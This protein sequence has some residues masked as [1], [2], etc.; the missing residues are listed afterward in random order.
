MVVFKRSGM[1]S[2]GGKEAQ[3]SFFCEISPLFFLEN[4]EDSGFPFLS[5][6]LNLSSGTKSTVDM[7]IP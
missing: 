2:A 1:G 5:Y 6:S 7:G 4:F 3:P